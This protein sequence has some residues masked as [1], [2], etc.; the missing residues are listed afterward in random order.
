MERLTD[1]DTAE[2]LRANA[3]KLLSKGM[4]VDISDLRY[5]KLA[6]YEENTAFEIENAFNQG[7]SEGY[8]QG[9]A[10][11]QDEINRLRE[12]IARQSEEEYD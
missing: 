6:E 8:E 7:Y 4:Q 1:R 11:A 3:E 10:K 5:I 2:A 12:Y 9:R